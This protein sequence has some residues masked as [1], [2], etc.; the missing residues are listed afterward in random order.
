MPFVVGLDIGTRYF[1]GAVVA[2]TRKSFR[3]VD[4]FLEEIPS[5][6]GQSSAPAG[7]AAQS[8]ER[9]SNEYA[10]PPSLEEVI[11]KAL[12]DRHLEGA[13]VVAAVDARDCV[14]RQFP[15]Q[16]TRD[17]Q[18]RKVI[19]FAAEEHFPAFSMDDV[20]LEYL[21]VG[22]SNGK[23]Q[24]L[25]AALRN[26]VLERRLAA[27]AKAGIDPVAMDLDC[28]ALVNAFALTKAYDPSRSVL[29]ADLGASSVRL[30]HIEGGRIR[31]MRSFRAAA[32]PNAE[33]AAARSGVGAPGL[34]APAG[35]SPGGIEARLGEIEAALAGADAASES[36]GTFDEMPV[37]ILS[38]EDFARIWEGSGEGAGEDV[39]ARYLERIAAEVHR[40]FASSRTKLDLICLS[41]GLSI[42]DD[43]LG[44]FAEE[45]GAEAT[46]LDLA[47]AIPADLEPERL[48]QVS[49]HGAIAVGLAAKEFGKDLYG[50]DFRKGRFRYERRF[51]RL[52]FPLLLLSIL[53]FLFFLQT[54]FWALYRYNQLS[55][56]ER[57]LDLRL[58]QA[59]ETFFGRPLA[60]GRDP[61]AAARSQ[62]DLWQKGGVGD[63]GRSIDAV[64]AIRN[65]GEVLNSTGMT[66]EVSSMKFEFD[67]RTRQDT[68]TKKMVWQPVADSSVEL[69]AKKD[70]A[71]I[72]IE[73]AFNE[74]PISKVFSASTDA[75]PTKEGDTRVN[76][77]LRV[78]PEY[79]AGLEKPKE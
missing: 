8:P 64:E 47:G 78:K 20:V 51:S 33:R 67:L 17:D 43:T 49:A 54:A 76:V 19:G 66:F 70:D 16:F 26:E 30:V 28:A 40:M 44:F 46:R 72:A 35:E 9:A 14:L 41:G 75:A 74:S 10:P 18:I 5:I 15:I 37:A 39:R 4:F 57:L 2:G 6:D 65:V 71:H 21:K 73:K 63:V 79:L 31:K 77:K 23:S 62:K 42:G 68:A 38:D 13:D 27:L 3:L 45:F 52:R 53:A 58:S 36:G 12:R 1:K 50:L 60:A 34:P 29:L 61:L 25:V 59:Y 11:A 48:E 56:T 24:L 32:A 55:E 7:A 22:E 69:I